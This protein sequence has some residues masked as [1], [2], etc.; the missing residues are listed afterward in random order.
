MMAGP[1]R[2]TQGCR[3]FLDQVPLDGAIA[4]LAAE[5][6]A[7]FSL[8]QLRALGLSAP[9]A[10]YR[11]AVGRLHRIHQGVYSLVPLELL[12]REGRW[13]A[14]VLA[15]GPG[16]VLSHRSAAALL[17]LRP[18]GWTRIEVTVPG[19]SGRRRDGIKV[20]RSTTFAA[21]DTTRVK[22]IPCTTTAR[23]LL[24][25]AAVIERRPLERA[26]DESE[27]LELFD[28]PS[29]NDQLE[30]NPNHAGVGIIRA[31]LE[32]H[33]IGST[34]TRNDLEEAFLA[35]CR[36]A[37]VP[38]P[39]VNEWVDFRDGGLP[40][41]ADFVWREQ[42]VLVETDG[43]RVHGTRRARERDPLRD[44]RA[45]LAGWR[46]IRTTRR[47]VMHRPHELQPTIVALVKL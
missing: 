38:D 6:H 4:G 39:Q 8:D 26:F 45:I 37:G 41:L 21:Q 14:A 29:L 42:R 13:M 7:V 12:T 11:A 35:L 3:A 19:R 15:C 33:Q 10:R 34:A 31:V 30:R 23:T 18:S 5:Q 22:N 25:L 9:A 36:R 16:A 44:Q 2:K 27:I 46:P 28:L 40:I 1:G 47:Q 32:E 17:A 20:H 43:R 24:D